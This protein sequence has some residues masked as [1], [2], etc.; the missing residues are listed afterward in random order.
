MIEIKV[1]SG[2]TTRTIKA[3]D[4]V[5]LLDILRRNGCV[6]HAPCGGKGTCG[7]CIV[8]AGGEG[9]VISCTYYPRKDIE[10]ILPDKTEAVI[11][12]DQTEFLFDLPMEQKS[13]VYATHQ[14]YGVAVD[15]GT[16]TVV[17]YFLELITGK[18][19]KIASFTNPQGSFGADVISRINHCQLHE[20]G[21]QE[22]QQA[23]IGA[24]NSE[25][26]KFANGRGIDR[27]SFEKVVFAGNTTMLHLL[28]GEDPVPIA[29]APFKPRF[30]ERQTRRGADSGLEVNAEAVI[31][32]LP[33]IS[34][35][36]GADIVAGLAALN[37][38]Q[39]NY[40]FTD[41]GT[42]GEIALITGS[43]IFVCAA[44][45]G[46]AFEGAGISCGMSALRGAVS[47]YS[48]PDSYRV[49]GNDRPAGICGSGI[50]DITAWLLDNGKID[51]TGYMQDEFPIYHGSSIF[52]TQRDIREIQLAKSAIY[53][54]MKI[55]L[56][57]RGL[58]FRDMDALFLA[59]GFGN[60]FNVESAL[61]IGLLPRDLAGKIHPVGNS[62]G[63]GALQYLKSGEF[64]ER[65]ETIAENA[66]YIE[67][68][69]DKDFAAQFALNIG[70]EEYTR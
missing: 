27:D 46:P 24:L 54:G 61:R 68:S 64:A 70:F 33:S 20:N 18:I 32:T 12:S 65:A 25:L 23:I 37:V 63:I 31:V 47:T 56:E 4:G 59:G 28:L 16:T 10:V 30:T 5:S 67:L 58:R 13:T 17:M 51:E 55:L 45:A 26:N 22:L 9:S 6:L 7:K 38:K 41:I 57:R 8:E 40:L 19:G 49:I 43:E 69:H 66:H 3:E 35:F 29:L 60:Y 15:L 36:V 11:L 21:L 39:E 62:A 14:P 48:G 53:S 2:D 44:A 52:L 34:A 50:V 42:N 1:I